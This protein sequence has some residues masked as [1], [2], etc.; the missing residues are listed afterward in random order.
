[1]AAL[2]GLVVRGGAGVGFV[3]AGERG[4]LGR[5]VAGIDRMAAEMP[6]LLWLMALKPPPSGVAI[7]AGLVRERGPVDIPDAAYRAMVRAAPGLAL[8]GPRG[9]AV[10]APG[11]RAASSSRSFA[12]TSTEV[13]TPLNST[14][15]RSAVG[16]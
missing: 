7:F 2:A 6:A 3:G 14:T 4:A 13:R 10:C 8:A 1:M 9:S 12:P 15:I 16:R 11:T 5:T